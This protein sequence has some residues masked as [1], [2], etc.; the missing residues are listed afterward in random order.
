ME[1]L[2]EETEV[3]ELLMSAAKTTETDVLL[4]HRISVLEDIF[5]RFLEQLTVQGFSES[6]NSDT[7]ESQRAADPRNKAGLYPI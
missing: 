2:L 6:G 5:S 4:P 3:Y 7:E 1:S